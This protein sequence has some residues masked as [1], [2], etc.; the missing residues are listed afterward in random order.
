MRIRGR[1]P[2]LRPAARR[3]PRS[4]SRRPV[5]AILITAAPRAPHVG[6]QVLEVRRHAREV[7]QGQDDALGAGGK[8]PVSAR[9]PPFHVD[10]VRAQL[11]RSRQQA[12][13]LVLGARESAPLPRGPARHDDRQAPARQCGSDIGAMHRVEPHFDQVG[14]VHGIAT[15]EEHRHVRS[16]D[17]NAE[18]GGLRGHHRVRA[19][20]QKTTQKNKKPLQPVRLKRLAAHAGTGRSRGRRRLPQPGTSATSGATQSI[21]PGAR[22][23]RGKPGTTSGETIQSEPDPSNEL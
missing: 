18:P 11:E 5:T 20:R 4:E 9:G 16:G 12:L 22:G 8:Q 23:G 1:S 2:S 7:V 3:V 21:A 19:G 6:C 14:I 10:V 15:R 17:R 13:A